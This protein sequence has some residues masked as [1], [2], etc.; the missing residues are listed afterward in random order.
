VRS[1]GNADPFHGLAIFS[2]LQDTDGAESKVLKSEIAQYQ[3]IVSAKFE[4]YTSSDPLD[5]GMTLWRATWSK[6]EQGCAQTLIDRAEDDTQKLWRS[7][8][9]KRHLGQRLAFREFG[10]A[11]GLK[12]ALIPRDERWGDRAESVVNSWE[13]AGLV[14]ELSE[15]SDVGMNATPDLM[16]ITSVM[17]AAALIP[18]GKSLT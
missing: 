5:L 7:S 18:G 2:L 10:L 4:E 17:Y 9:F 1:E 11:L 16:P 13:R 15:E 6:K 14:P 12:V 8:Y 3:T